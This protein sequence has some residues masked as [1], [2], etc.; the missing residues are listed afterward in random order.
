ML[1]RK[2][3][4]SLVNSF[5][6]NANSFYSQLVL[7]SRFYWKHVKTPF[8]IRE[9][10]PRIHAIPKQMLLSIQYHLISSREMSDL[11][12]S[13]VWNMEY[14]S[15]RGP[16]LLANLVACF[17]WG[18]A[19]GLP[20]K[21]VSLVTGRFR[22]I[23]GCFKQH[24]QQ[25]KSVWYIVGQVHSSLKSTW[26]E[27][28]LLLMIHFGKIPPRSQPSS[29]LLPCCLKSHQPLEKNNLVGQQRKRFYR[30]WVF[31]DLSCYS[32]V[33]SDIGPEPTCLLSIA[34]TT[35][36]LQAA[37]ECF[38]QD[39]QLLR[40]KQVPTRTFFRISWLTKQSCNGKAADLG[41]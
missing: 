12:K 11:W 30:K 31:L 2:G 5:G 39:I 24:G 6:N 13:A 37:G 20:Q 41:Y 38:F 40:P 26:L 8:S 16:L 7:G 10:E 35:R 9:S 18:E 4:S 22:V 3:R 17:C 28:R 25:R 36:N 15:E 23:H 32:A 19:A 29:R 33:G 34:S 21:T 14:P 27:R 1:C